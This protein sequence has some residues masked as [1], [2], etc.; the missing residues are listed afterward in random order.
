MG[1]TTLKKTQYAELLAPFEQVNDF[2]TSSLVKEKGENLTSERLAQMHSI[3]AMVKAI[4]T[5]SGV[6]SYLR[7]LRVI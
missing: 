3:E 1:V 6:V 7:V 2:S 5:K 4:L